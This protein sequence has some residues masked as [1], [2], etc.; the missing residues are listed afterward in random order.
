[1]AESKDLLQVLWSEQMCSEER[2]MQMSTK[3]IY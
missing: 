1:M 3:H 2:W